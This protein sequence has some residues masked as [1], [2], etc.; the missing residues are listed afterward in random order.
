MH[1]TADGAPEATAWPAWPEPSPTPAP[2]VTD[3]PPTFAI[4]TSP[5]D[6][7]P[8]VSDADGGSLQ[9]YD[10]PTTSNLVDTIVGDVVAGFLGT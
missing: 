6:E 2:V 8:L 4:E 3:A 5:P 7:G 10:P 1:A 9:V